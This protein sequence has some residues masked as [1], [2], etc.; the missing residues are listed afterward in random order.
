MQRLLVVVCLVLFA[1]VAFAAVKDSPKIEP[2]FTDIRFEI[3]DEKLVFAAKTN[4]PSGTLIQASICKKVPDTMYHPDNF[5][6]AAASLESLSPQQAVKAEALKVHDGLVTGWFPAIYVKGMPAD[7]S[8]DVLVLRI[9]IE[10][11]QTELGPEN[12]WLSGQGVETSFQSE[13]K[14]YRQDFSA[15]LPAGLFTLPPHK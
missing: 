7:V 5:I 15:Q 9:L 6:D 10:T 4:L 11:A 14:I 3:Q 1:H 12:A 13:R 8:A 2:Q